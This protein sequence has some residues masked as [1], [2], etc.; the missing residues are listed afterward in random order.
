M[1]KILPFT[2]YTHTDVEER[3][4][5]LSFPT[6]A[7]IDRE[8]ERRKA[9]GASSLSDLPALSRIAARLEPMLRRLFIHAVRATQNQIELEALAQAIQSGRVATRLNALAKLE[10]FERRLAGYEGPLRRGFLQGATFANSTLLSAGLTMNFAIMDSH[11]MVFAQRYTPVL[12]ESIVNGGRET[13][14]RII[15][16]AVTFGDTP[17]TAAR[18]IRRNIGFTPRDGAQYRKIEAELEAAN[19]AGELS[20]GQLERKLERVANGLI[21]RRATTIA[22][23]EVI[24]AANAGQLSTWH[25]AGAE[26]LLDT[27]TTKKKWLATDDELLEAT[28][29]MLDGMPAIGLS[30]EFLPGVMAPPQHPNCRCAM[31]LEFT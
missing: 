30:E 26:G 13:I 1:A 29:R 25:E 16:D 17:Q 11:A 21:N 24:R 4:L 14:R 15:E 22:R 31:F 27:Q 20:D 9:L 28:C 10:V 12:V 6:L 23:T 3:A 18:R 8:V 19:L 5:A 2:K 7:T